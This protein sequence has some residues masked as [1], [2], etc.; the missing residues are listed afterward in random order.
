MKEIIK[1]TIDYAEDYAKNF[2]N[3][4]LGYSRKFSGLWGSFYTMMYGNEM[5]P[6]MDGMFFM[7][8]K[9]IQFHEFLL[10][11]TIIWLLMTI[12][13]SVVGFILPV[14]LRAYF[15]VPGQYQSLLQ[16]LRRIAYTGF[17][18]VLTVL[19]TCCCI[20]WSNR[21]LALLGG[22]TFIIICAWI[23]LCSVQAMYLFIQIVRFLA[24]LV[25]RL[26]KG[27]LWVWLTLL[28]EIYEHT[29]KL[30]RTIRSH[31][32]IDGMNEAEANDVESLTAT[33]S[34]VKL[35]ELPCNC[36]VLKS[37]QSIVKGTRPRKV[38]YIVKLA[39]LAKEEFGSVALSV[40]NR[41]MIRKF[42]R[43]N[44]RAT[45]VRF[46]HLGTIIEEAT[47]LYFIPTQEELA[48]KD[49]WKGPIYQHLLNK[50]MNL[51]GPTDEFGFPI[52]TF[53]STA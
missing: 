53:D 32:L 9:H 2:D 20:G 12:V 47:N 37:K 17:A 11:S 19:A 43:D 8:D 25:W 1:Y 30:K 24:G 28:R 39:L 48:C 3:V 14:V 18:V 35:S 13:S 34:C 21:M 16:D 26:V 50:Q 36:S 33:C 38:A 7:M 15:R 49:V 31:E 10:E 52:R 4:F 23:S 41:M 29:F 45:N 44:A 51:E 6:T 22:S 42:M 46:A 27:I 40:A 5:V